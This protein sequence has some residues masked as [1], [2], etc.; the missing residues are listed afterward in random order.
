MSPCR[1]QVGASLRR[2]QRSQEVHAS[3]SESSDCAKS[4]TGGFWGAAHPLVVSS[5]FASL[6]TEQFFGGIS[7][8]VKT[9]GVGNETE[10][11]ALSRPPGGHPGRPPD[12]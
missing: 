3:F 1:R 6:K 4:H 11:C 5:S 8:Y 12:R 9:T 10:L 2:S 7:H